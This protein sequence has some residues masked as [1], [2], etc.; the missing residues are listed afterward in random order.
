[1]QFPSPTR[2]RRFRPRTWL[3]SIVSTWLHNASQSDEVRLRAGLALAGLAHD[4][5]QWSAA[6]Y[7]F[8]AEQLV[9][10]E[11]V[12]QPALWRLLDDF[13]ERLLEPLETVFAQQ[14]RTEKELVAAAHA[15]VVPTSRD[16]C[17]QT[18]LR[19]RIGLFDRRR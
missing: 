8:L 11:G 10:I 14:T 15:S 1:M 9:T 6:D 17:A 3:P 4:D 7:Q 19:K 13:G 18:N 2:G 16:R 5:T 12:Y